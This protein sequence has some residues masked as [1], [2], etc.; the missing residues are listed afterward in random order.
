MYIL[1]ER[2]QHSSCIWPTT[3]YDLNAVSHNPYAYVTSPEQYRTLVLGLPVDVLLQ[4]EEMKLE[5]EHYELYIMN[6]QVLRSL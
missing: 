2:P 3:D 4:F 1:T 5:H 6:L